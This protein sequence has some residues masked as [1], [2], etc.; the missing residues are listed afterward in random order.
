M[1]FFDWVLSIPQK[2]LVFFGYIEPPEED[3]DILLKQFLIKYE[4]PEIR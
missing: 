2:I 1:S 3:V 4:E